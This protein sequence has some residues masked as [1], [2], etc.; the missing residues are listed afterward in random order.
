[1]RIHFVIKVWLTTALIGSILNSIYGLFFRKP[2]HLPKTLSEFF[3]RMMAG[4]VIGSLVASSFILPMAFL[5]VYA[6]RKVHINIK[7]KI[8]LTSCLAG[9]FAIA[10][11]AL[12]AKLVYGR[13]EILEIRAGY[14]AL[15]SY[16][17]VAFL[18]TIH[19]GKAY[20]NHE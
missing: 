17:T 7:L 12:S 19:F 4:E 13:L 20:F 18:S 10:I 1:M 11:I 8:I 5:A 16:V 14:I 6:I 2:V 15:V 9:L 3:L